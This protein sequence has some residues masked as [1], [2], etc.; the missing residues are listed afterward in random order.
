M[1]SSVFVSTLIN[2]YQHHANLEI[3]LGQ[4]KYLKNKFDFFG[5]KTP[6]R[7]LISRPFLVENYLP[8]KVLLAE[9]IHELWQK[10]QRELH[11][12]GQELVFKYKKKF[13]TKDILI[14]EFMLTHQS[15]WDT[16]DFI[17]SKIAA[18]YFQQFPKQIALII[19]KWLASE[20]IWLQRAAL[21]FQ[22]KYKAATDTI[23]LENTI[24]SLIPS[25]AFFINKAIGWI[26]REYSRTNPK[27]VLNFVAETP[28]AAL[29]K[30][31]ALRLT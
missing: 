4:A 23:L 14:I 28:L 15:W 29:S 5:I 2:E 20:N 22:L 16:V 11:Y 6:E 17:A 8:Q 31:E 25:E 1:K 27:W 9:I 24:N 10:P 30:R 13:E 21:L 12:F 7:R 18:A 19:P 26:L 3:A